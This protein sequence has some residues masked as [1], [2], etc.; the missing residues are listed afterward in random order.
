MIHCVLTR[1]YKA[2]GT[3]IKSLNSG[4]IGLMLI[5]PYRDIYELEIKK[6]VMSIL[7]KVD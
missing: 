3:R 1:A 6:M 5:W 4:G 7:E 2:L